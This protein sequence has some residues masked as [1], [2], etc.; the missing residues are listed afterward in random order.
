MCLGLRALGGETSPGTPDLSGGRGR[1]QG[2]VRGRLTAATASTPRAQS[3]G[4]FGRRQT[5]G[6]PRSRSFSPGQALQGID[7]HFK[8]LPD[9]EAVDCGLV[10][11]TLL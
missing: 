1:W 8:T 7:F 5:R 10:G 4:S 9:P 2:S 6:E 11:F 3:A